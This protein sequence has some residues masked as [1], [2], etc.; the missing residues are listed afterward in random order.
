MSLKFQLGRVE[1]RMGNQL[2]GILNLCMLMLLTPSVV[3]LSDNSV[4]MLVWAQ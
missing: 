2:C 1:A 3:L 4:H